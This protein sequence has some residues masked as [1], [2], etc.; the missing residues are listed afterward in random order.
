M[1][2][3]SWW[4]FRFPSR[5]ACAARP[6]GLGPKMRILRP[7]GG[8]SPKSSPSSAEA[9]ENLLPMGKAGPSSGFSSRPTTG[10]DPIGRDAHEQPSRKIGAER[11]SVHARGPLE[12]RG[13]PAPQVGP[14][15]GSPQ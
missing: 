1:G 12:R 7:P 6:P 10:L 14:V 15:R 9:T 8:V 2:R 3:R 5:S 4:I 11:L 13:S